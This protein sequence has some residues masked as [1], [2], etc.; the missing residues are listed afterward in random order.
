VQAAPVSEDIRRIKS[1]DDFY[2]R[3]FAE[4]D[5]R[6][7]VEGFYAEEA[8]LMSPGAPAAQGHDAI[9][10]M[11]GALAAAGGKDLLLRTETVDVS[12]DMAYSTG[13]YSLTIAPANA[14]EIRD[15]GKF[16]VVFRRRD[17]DWRAVADMFNTDNSAV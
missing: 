1:F 5:L 10:G 3:K 6:G 13:T 2:A 12:G 15:E 17:G 11:L 14:E 9:A 8:T 7:L 4:G 16:L